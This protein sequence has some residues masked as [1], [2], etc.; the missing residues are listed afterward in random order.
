MSFAANGKSKMITNLTT[1]GGILP[2]QS[3][4]IAHLDAV[5]FVSIGAG[6]N[7]FVILCHFSFF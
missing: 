5:A 4:Y 1:M 6:V 2:M 3:A 7:D